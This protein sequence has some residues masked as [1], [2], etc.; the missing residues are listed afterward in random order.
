MN[1]FKL[2]LRSEL[3]LIL[4]VTSILPIVIL[5]LRLTDSEY[6]KSQEIFLNS[7]YSTIKD[8]DEQIEGLISTNKEHIEVL[9]KN[10]YIKKSF[11][12]G[13]FRGNTVEVFKSLKDTGKNILSVYMGGENGET[14]LYP[15]KSLDKSYDPRKRDWYTSVKGG[16]EAVVTPPYLDSFTSTDIITISKSVKNSSNQLVGVVAIDIQLAQLSELVSKSKIGDKGFIFVTYNNENIIASSNKNYVGKDISKQAFGNELKAIKDGDKIEIDGSKYI[17]KKVVD[18]KNGY[19][20]Y[21]FV[22]KSEVFSLTLRNIVVPLIFSA[23]CIIF[24]T[25]VMIV[26]SGKLSRVARKIVDILNECKDGNFTSRIEVNNVTTKEFIEIAECANLMMD[27]MVRVLSSA[28]NASRSMRKES[29]SLNVVVDEFYDGSKDVAEAMTQLAQGTLEQSASLEEGVN[30]SVDIG[31]EI[32]KTLECSR[33]VINNSQRVQNTVSEGMVVAQELKEIQKNNYTS[34]S[35][36]VN[37]SNI[38]EG[39]ANKVNDIIETIKSI[40]QQTNLL[41]LNASIEAA[42]AGEAGRGFAVVADEIGKLANETSSSAEE[43]E[44]IINSNIEDINMVVVEVNNS[45]DIVEKT[46]E[47]VEKTYKQFEDINKEID[48]L[49]GFIV[50]VNDNI[51]NMEKIKDKFIDKLQSISAVSQEAAAATE[52]VN[53]ST[54]TQLQR[55]SELNSSS[56]NLERLATEVYDIIEKFKI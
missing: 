5:G 23:I 32:S 52:E 47:N 20:A 17:V 30:L 35:N 6:Q 44:S 43:I 26:V 27:D 14:L 31:D 19:T 16:D 34:I 40:S 2:K 28:G 45:R 49:K 9:S 4:I 29:E 55:I 37:K 38:L 3:M 21:G 39:N 11:E 24:A 15:S 13:D 51:T 18:D 46:S 12:E 54:D 10:P 7:A 42:R 56:Q 33:E 25:G 48:L 1:K 8:V 50:E 41:A 53:A 36:V 22:N